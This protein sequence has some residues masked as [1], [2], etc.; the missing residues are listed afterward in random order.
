[1]C[2]AQV[3]TSSYKA[4]NVLRGASTSRSNLNLITSQKPYF[5]TFPEPPK[6]ALPS[7]DQVFNA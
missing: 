1:V 2:L 3:S 7:G 6:L 5:L 4:T